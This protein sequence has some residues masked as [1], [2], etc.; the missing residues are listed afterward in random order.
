METEPAAAREQRAGSAAA[1]Q[2]ANRAASAAAMAAMHDSRLKWLTARP[3]Q[4]RSTGGAVLRAQR[5]CSNAEANQTL[6]GGAETMRAAPICMGDAH[7]GQR[8]RDRGHAE[9]SRAARQGARARGASAAEEAVPNLTHDSS[10]D[11]EDAVGERESERRARMQFG[12]ATRPTWSKAVVLTAAAK[13]RVAERSDESGR[14]RAIAAMRDKR[15]AAMDTTISESTSGGIDS[16]VRMWLE[17]CPTW[18]AHDPL[19]H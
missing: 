17:F 15:Q 18:C 14:G 12:A 5:A 16:A 7:G 9:P 1:A 19:T 2:A 4:W 6:L 13:A 10:D 11:D 8:Q 3:V